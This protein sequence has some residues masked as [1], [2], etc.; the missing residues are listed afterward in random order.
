MIAPDSYGNFNAVDFGARPDDS[1]IDSTDALQAT[2]DAACGPGDPSKVG[3]NAIG[4]VFLPPG[5]YRVSKPLRIH[6]VSYLRFFGAGRS[7]RIYPVGKMESVLDLNGVAYST[8]A[9]FRIEGTNSETIENVIYFYWDQETAVR[10]SCGDIFKDI[11]I[12]GTRCVT[13][14]RIGKPGSLLQVDSSSYSNL[15]I[16][17]NWNTK[18]KTW[19]Q[20]GFYVGSDV[21]GNNLVHTFN[22]ISLTGFNKGFTVTPTNFSLTG[23]SLGQNGTDF[24]IGNLSYFSV[25]GVRSEQSQR[26]AEI[27]MGPSVPGN[28]SFSDCIWESSELPKDN[29]V[30]RGQFNGCLRLNNIAFST[31]PNLSKIVVNS[32]NG[33]ALIL[34]GISSP[35]DLESLTEGSTPK[36]SVMARG[37]SKIDKNGGF[38]GFISSYNQELNL[39]NGQKFNS[40]GLYIDT[41]LQWIQKD[42]GNLWPQNG[43]LHFQNSEGKIT[44]IVPSNK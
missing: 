7:T 12:H 26:F 20:N 43:G 23:G 32:P 29:V 3:R 16:S 8:F 18:E 1:N 30:I 14:F 13:G 10:S 36:L 35:T 5:T 37:Y 42:G 24:N 38:G 39:E 19:Y 44:T 28:W 34:D 27:M 4:N 21:W 41:T 9:D 15:I 6:S 31:R 11:L 22:N 33:A 17:G 25:N 2:I 40:N